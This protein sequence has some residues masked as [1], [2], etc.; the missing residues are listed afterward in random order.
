MNKYISPYPDLL[1]IIQEKGLP[2]TNKI[3]IRP[4]VFP[5]ELYLWLKIQKY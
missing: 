3:K 1:D 2:I 4:K 5:Y